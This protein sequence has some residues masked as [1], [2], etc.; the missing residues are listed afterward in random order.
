MASTE[1]E[2]VSRG[3]AEVKAVLWD[4]VELILLELDGLDRAAGQ[5]VDTNSQ[6]SP[7]DLDRVVTTASRHA[8]DC[9]IK[10]GWA[11][12]A[13]AM[14]REALAPSAVSVDIG[15]RPGAEPID[16]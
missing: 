3:I 12:K 2:L 16:E 5:L 7:A 13:V 1:D 8:L 6:P 14:F 9:V 4:G 10:L 15:R 11:A